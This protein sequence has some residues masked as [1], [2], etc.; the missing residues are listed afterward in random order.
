MN[1]FLRPETIIEDELEGTL[2]PRLLKEIIGREKEKKSIVIMIEAARQ[3]KEPIDHIL[4]HGP[5][6]LGKTTMA[7]AIA[8][9]LGVELVSTSG[10]ARERKGDL[11]S[12]LSSLSDKTVLFI[13]EVHRLNKPIEEMLYSAMEDRKLD[14]VIG[15][16]PSARTLKLDLN[17]FTI[18]GATTRVGMLSS[19]FRDRFGVDMYLDYYS[20]EELE[21]LIRQ[22]AKILKIKIKDDAASEIA[23][24]ARRTPRIAIRLLKRMRDLAQVSNKDE[25][26]MELTLNGMKLIDIDS[27]GLDRLDKKILTTINDLFNGGPVGLNTIATTLAEDIDT[28]RDV[29]EPY[30][31]KE[32]FIIRTPKGRML[33]QK[34]IDYIANYEF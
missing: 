19:P 2:R 6:G 8:N 23:R 10:L 17:P 16:G 33:T 4:F 11:V 21:E 13:D 20:F 7:L 9:E 18:I 3:R 25:I 29:Y 30:L 26:D 27:H 31:L 28:I 1:D 14:I 15:K 22:K 24:R 5:P 32:G 34:S 12:I